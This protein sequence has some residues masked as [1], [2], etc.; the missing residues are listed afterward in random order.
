MPEYYLYI[1]TAWIVDVDTVYHYYTEIHDSGMESGGYEYQ[2]YTRSADGLKDTILIASGVMSCWVNEYTPDGKLLSRKELQLQSSQDSRRIWI[3]G[4]TIYNEYDSDGRIIATKRYG[5]DKAPVY[6]M[7]YEYAGSSVL[8]STVTA[9]DVDKNITVV[10]KFGIEPTADGYVF[11]ET[12]E[13]SDHTRNTVKRDTTV[14][15]YVF[16]SEKR[17]IRAGDVVYTWLEDGGYIETAAYRTVYY[18]SKGYPEKMRY[19]YLYDG[20]N[21]EAETVYSYISTSQQP[22]SPAPAEAVSGEEV[23]GTENGIVVKSANPVRA[24]IYTVD[25]KLVKQTSV[26]EDGGLIGLPGGLYIVR[27]EKASY[28][29]FVGK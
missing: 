22:Q 10:K 11:E 4:W 28:K 19:S 18:N 13:T 5:Y 29:V 23:Y 6:S 25:G 17:L 9:V 20:A 16:D 15:E 27:T 2:A 8:P 12:A 3:E 24:T 14:L 7:I 26:N 1:N 21:V